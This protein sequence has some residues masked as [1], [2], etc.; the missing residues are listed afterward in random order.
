MV[1]KLIVTF[2]PDP[3]TR[4]LDYLYGLRSLALDPE[5]IDVIYDLDSRISL[6]GWISENIDAINYYLDRCLQVCHDCFHPWEQ[7]AVQIFAAPIAQSFGINALCNLQTD[8]ITILVDIGRVMP[9]D[10]L[11]LVVHEYAHAHAGSPGHHE[12]YA[13]SLA[14]LCL[15][16][17]IAPPMDQC[18][19][20]LRFHPDC[21]PTRNPLSTWRGEAGDWLSSITNS[22]VRSFSISQST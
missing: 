8:P 12:H 14:H 20:T 10:W 15:G 3:V 5:M 22:Y 7:P 18:E 9:E 11:L 17:G 19:D 1:S 6:C 13:R 4:G 21:L 16:L 2:S